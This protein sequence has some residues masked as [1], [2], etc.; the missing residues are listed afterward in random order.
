MLEA[1][2]L[3]PRFSALQGVVPLG[4]VM[5]SA[6][7]QGRVGNLHLYHSHEV[8]ANLTKEKIIPLNTLLASFPGS[9]HAASDG[10]LAWE[11]G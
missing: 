6:L 4:D 5:G 10:K 8:F 11:R 7:Q 2:L 9:L 1:L 3:V